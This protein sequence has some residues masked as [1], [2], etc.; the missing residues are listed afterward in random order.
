MP[1][2]GLVIGAGVLIADMRLMTSRQ[3]N[4]GSAGNL[5]AKPCAAKLYHA[6]FII[7]HVNS[8]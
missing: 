1:A 2:P 7:H 3:G 8:F 6:G 5:T 4:R